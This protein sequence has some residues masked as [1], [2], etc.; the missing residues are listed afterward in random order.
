MEDGMHGADRQGHEQTQR[1]AEERQGQM[2]EHI[3]GQKRVHG[4]TKGQTR[5]TWMNRWATKMDSYMRHTD[6]STGI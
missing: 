5:R 1:G 6:R 3:K 4:G 2:D